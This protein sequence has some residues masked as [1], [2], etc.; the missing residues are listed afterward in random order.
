M[1]RFGWSRSSRALTVVLELMSTHVTVPLRPSMITSLVRM[2]NGRSESLPSCTG[3]LVGRSGSDLPSLA[4]GPFPAELG[5]SQLPDCAPRKEVAWGDLYRSGYHR[6]ITHLHHFYTPRNYL[7]LATLWDLVETFDDDLQDALRL[8]ILSFNS[9]HSTLMTRV[10][11]KK[12][13]NDLV[14]TGAQSGVLYVSGLPVE[15]NIFKGVRRKIRT[16]ADAFDLVFERQAPLTSSMRAA[17]RS[18]FRMRACSTS[19][20][21]HRSAITSRTQRSIRSMKR[22][23]ER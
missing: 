1:H 7:A 4:T 5:R 23:S 8:L 12:G 11:V 3:R 17:R 2:S 18:T 13:Q 9:T 20:L 21:I 15:K 16:I 14:L 6:G 22:G 10:V 19:S